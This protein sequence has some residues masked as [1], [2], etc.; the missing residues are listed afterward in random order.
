MQITTQGIKYAYSLSFV[1][2]NATFSNDTRCSCKNCPVQLDLFKLV[3]L[4]LA[5]IYEKVSST[6]VNCVLF[7]V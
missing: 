3:S 1:N 7:S 4:V 5:K 2:I 6:F